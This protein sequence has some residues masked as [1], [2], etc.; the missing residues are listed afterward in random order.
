MREVC[1]DSNAQGKV[2]LE[3]LRENKS[4]GVKDFRMYYIFIK[5]DNE[6]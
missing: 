4:G 2:W 1:W 5:A 3:R 6:H